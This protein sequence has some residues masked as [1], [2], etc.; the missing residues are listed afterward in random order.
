M[1]ESPT[2]TADVA[3]LPGVLGPSFD[4][5]R[6]SSPCDVLGKYASG[7]SPAVPRDGCPV[8]R[9]SPRSRYGVSCTMRASSRLIPRKIPSPP[10]N[11][12]SPGRSR[13]PVESSPRSSLREGK[14]VSFARL[15]EWRDTSRPGSLSTVLEYLVARIETR[16]PCPRGE[17]PGNGRTCGRGFGSQKASSVRSWGIFRKPKGR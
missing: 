15:E 7:P 6:T 5:P 16:R 13:A 17:G 10:A 9:P 11:L 8:A 12:K 1:H 3:V 4:R 14:R 2:T